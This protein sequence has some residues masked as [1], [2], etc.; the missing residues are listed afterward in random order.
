M[1]YP[2][3][4][5]LDRLANASYQIVIRDRVTGKNYARTAKGGIDSSKVEVVQL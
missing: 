3:N 2:R 5:A 4:S 1:T